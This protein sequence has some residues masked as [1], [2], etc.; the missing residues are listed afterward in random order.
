MYKH[1]I[2]FDISDCQATCV[3]LKALEMPMLQGADIF[4]V[5]VQGAGLKCLLYDKI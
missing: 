1:D 4:S 3:T 2:N 5:R